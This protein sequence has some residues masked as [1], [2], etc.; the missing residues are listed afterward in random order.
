MDDLAA[1][2]Q[3]QENEEAKAKKAP[4]SAELFSSVEVFQQMH[5]LIDSGVLTLSE[6]NDGRR[7]LS[8][9][10]RRMGAMARVVEVVRAPSRAWGMGGVETGME[11]SGEEYRALRSAMDS[12][13][14][15]APPVFT[16]EEVK[17]AILRSCSMEAALDYLESLRR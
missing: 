15:D 7:M 3:L 12:A 13:L 11:F 2:E 4:T 17:T 16:L 9:L 14:T 8:L 10:E 5:G 6:Q 1:I